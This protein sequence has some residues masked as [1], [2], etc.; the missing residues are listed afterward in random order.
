MT[1]TFQNYY[2]AESQMTSEM[3]A[4]M[5]DLLVHKYLYY[6]MDRP[7]I[8]DYEYDMMESKWFR[9]LEDAGINMDKYP[10]AVG[11]PHSHPLAEQAVVKAKSLLGIEV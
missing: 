10:F 3:K 8:T 6:E 4:L 2:K 5:L 7:V 11:F 9:M 1:E